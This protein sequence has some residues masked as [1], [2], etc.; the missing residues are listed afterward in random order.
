MENSKVYT[1]KASATR[2][3][4]NAI[5]KSGIEAEIIINEVE[6]GFTFQIE[7]QVPSKDFLRVSEIETPCS[8]VWD[9]ASSMEGA[10]RK[11]VIA[12]CTKQGIAFYTARTQYQLWKQAGKVSEKNEDK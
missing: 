11:D 6:G 4:K 9:I 10:K 8:V 1:A 7:V 12:E 2:A 5:T 3:A